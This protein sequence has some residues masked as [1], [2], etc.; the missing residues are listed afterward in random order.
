MGVQAWRQV[1]KIHEAI[2]IIA[3]TDFDECVILDLITKTRLGA[4]FTESDIIQ[5]ETND[6]F[7]ELENLNK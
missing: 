3:N 7:L 5:I 2:E 6:L 4:Q 1:M